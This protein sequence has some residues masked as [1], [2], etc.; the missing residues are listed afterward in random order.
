[1]RFSFLPFDSAVPRRYRCQPESAADTARVAP[2]FTS[3]RYGVAAYCQL[4]RATT[5]LI[6]RG[7]DDESE[8]GAFHS[9]FPAQRETNLQIRLREF[10]RVGLAAGISYET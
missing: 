8:M 10:L 7:A 6:R 4:A 9:L 5:D 3:L 2:R 1:M